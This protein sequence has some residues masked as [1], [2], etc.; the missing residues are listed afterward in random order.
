MLCDWCGE[1]VQVGEDI[2][3]LPEGSTLCGDWKLHEAVTRQ[4]MLVFLH[5]L[6][7]GES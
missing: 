4:D 3:T 2:Y 5:R 7:G 1:E 6:A